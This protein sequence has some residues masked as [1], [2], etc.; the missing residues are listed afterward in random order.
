[1]NLVKSAIEMLRE[2]I[3]YA[4]KQFVNGINVSRLTESQVKTFQGDQEPTE[5]QKCWKSSRTPLYNDRRR[6]THELVDINKI[7]CGA[8]QEVLTENPN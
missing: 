8:D 4:V 5:R 7:S 3:L 1:V 2:N 6:T